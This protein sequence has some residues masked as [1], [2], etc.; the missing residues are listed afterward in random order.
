MRILYGIFA[1]FAWMYLLAYAI[2][3][4]TPIS[5]EFQFLTLSIVIA[6]AMAGGD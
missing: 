2:S 4:G 1:A 5:N 6:G 3:T